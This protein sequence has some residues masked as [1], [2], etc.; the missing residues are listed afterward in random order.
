MCATILVV[1]DEEKILDVITSYL[2]KNGYSVRKAFTGRQALDIF[3]KDEPQCIIL[4]LMLP[5]LSGE[6]VCQTIR[7]K[8]RVPIL[9]LTAKAEEK[10]LLGGFTIGADDYMTKPF[11]PRELL[12]RI[13]ALL[14]RTSAGAAPLTSGYTYQN[15]LKIDTVKK[16]VTK[17]GNIVKLTHHEYMLLL[18]FAS[19]PGRTFTRDELIRLSFGTD[20]SGFDRTIDAHIKN[21]RRKIETNPK[22][23]DLIIT[24]HGIGYRFE[25]GQDETPV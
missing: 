16:T 1:E 4:D 19:N 5:D 7:R 21:L 13:A 23:P 17:N 9:M 10:D 3:N 14:R 2:E 11:S 6:V 18:V 12:A 24:V 8:S 25:E 20:F 15:G 22:E